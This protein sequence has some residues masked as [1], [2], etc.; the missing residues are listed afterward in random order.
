[1]V[2]NLDASPKCCKRMEQSWL[3]AYD[4]MGRLTYITVK[5]FLAAYIVRLSIFFNSTQSA[6]R[7]LKFAVL[8][9]LLQHQVTG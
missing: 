1:M 6:D 4:F 3:L 7:F 5:I 8:C 9:R 2:S